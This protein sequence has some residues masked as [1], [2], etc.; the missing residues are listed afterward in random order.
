MSRRKQVPGITVWQRPERKNTWTYQIELEADPLTGDRHRESKGGFAT[1]NAA[2]TA[3]IEA[4][5]RQETGQAAH[6]KRIRVK[7][8]LEQWHGATA[9]SL[10]PS[11]AQNDLDYINGYIVPVLG[12]RWLGDITVPVVN[13]FYKH[14]AEAGRRKTDTNSRMYKYWIDR[15][16]QRGGLGPNP[17]EMAARFGITLQGAQAAARRYR[18]GRIP[19]SGTAGLAP[20]TIRNIHG[21]MNRALKDAVRWGYLYANPAEHAV[22]PRNKRRKRGADEVWTVPQLVQWLAVALRDRYSGIWLLVANTGMRRSELA[23]IERARLDL[24]EGV[25]ELE[26]TRVVVAGRAQISDGKTTAGVRG[27][28][29]DGFTVEWLRRYLAMI[30]EEREALGPEYPDHDYLMVGP[31]GRPLHPDTIT[32]RFNRLVDQAGVPRI[33][34]HDVRHT[35]ATWALDEGLG[36]KVLSDRIGHAHPG[37]TYGIYTHRSTG[38]DRSMAEQMGALLRDALGARGLP[39]ATNLA[40]DDGSE[41]ETRTDPGE[42]GQQ[43]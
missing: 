12:E 34:L 23:G 8:Y 35:Y 9:P 36:G 3:A 40:T 30:N 26:D 11:A 18:R 38:R 39:L 27:I 10:K 33:R 17:R 14:L 16:D 29:L 6:A 32:R 15:K 13:A 4:K 24:D 43:T 31:E 20:K 41:A 28:S 25:L 5:R 1:Y 22:V 37:I 2:L 42:A 21:V 7:D 19:S